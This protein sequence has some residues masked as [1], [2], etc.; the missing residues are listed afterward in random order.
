MVLTSWRPCHVRSANWYNYDQKKTGLRENY[1][2][3]R[4]KVSFLDFRRPTEF[5]LV[6]YDAFWGVRYYSVSPI[7]QGASL[8]SAFLQCF[9]CRFNLVPTKTP[10]LY[11]GPDS[12]STAVSEQQIGLKQGRLPYRNIVQNQQHNIPQKWLS[13]V[14]NMTIITFYPT[15]GYHICC[16]FS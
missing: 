10:T 16:L 9:S 2:I 15:T 6:S 4:K 12:E 13:T 5:K 14:D 7:R 1:R 11:S 3:F 8:I